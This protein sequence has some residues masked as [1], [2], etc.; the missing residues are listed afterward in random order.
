MKLINKGRRAAVENRKMITSH[1]DL[2]RLASERIVL[3][4]VTDL[5][6]AIREHEGQ[7][8]RRPIGPRPHDQALYR[9]LRQAGA[10]RVSRPG[11]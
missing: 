5:A 7:T 8:T 2:A 10:T 11:H 4:R 1:A 6:G 3:G 9:R